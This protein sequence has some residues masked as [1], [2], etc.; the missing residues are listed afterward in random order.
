MVSRWGWVQTV[1]R[2]GLADLRH[3][4]A[5][6]GFWE[7]K[8]AGKGRKSQ[9][10][11]DG[12]QGKGAVSSQQSAVRSQQLA[13]SNQSQGSSPVRLGKKVKETTYR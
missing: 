7:G 5:A 11:R 3:K 9:Y 12:W 6:Q 2:L 4:V 10:T 8:V 1:Q 13:V